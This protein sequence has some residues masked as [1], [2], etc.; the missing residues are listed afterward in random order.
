VRAGI[1]AIAA[2]AEASFRG[3]RLLWRADPWDGWRATSPMKNVYVGAAG[4]ILALAELRD[5]GLAET[6][7]DLPALALR[8]LELFRARP[9]FQRGLALPD[10]PVAGLLT[11]ETGILL[12]AWRLAPGP[13]LED[14]IHELVRANVDNEA[15]DVMW[16][17]PGTL[18]AARELLGRTGAPRWRDACR[19]TADALLARRGADGLWVQRLYGDEFRG[20]GTAHGLVGNVQALR[21]ALDDERRRA[22]ERDAAAI[23]ARTAFVEA[24]LANWPYF[25]RPDLAGADGQIR[26]QWCCGAPGVVCAAA[27]YLDEELLL[28]AAE[29]VWRAGPH[30]GEKGSS[31]CHGTAGNGYALLETFERTQDGRWLDRARR[32]AVHALARVERAR[33]ERGRGRHSLW[34][35]DPGV[36]LF[37][38]DCLA[39]RARYPLFDS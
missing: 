4:V 1:R 20:L 2:D 38:A 26:L 8:T 28:A 31:I 13:E 23:L 29:L 32:F 37:A 35:G 39:A 11:G 17:A 19:E 18:V 21:P 16:G 33:T 14:R 10:P 15:E 5:R 36:A 27:D 6:R 9:D 12:V 34:T 24:G 3:P 7:L 25:E 22:L 30:G